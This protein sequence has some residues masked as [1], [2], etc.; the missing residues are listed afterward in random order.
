MPAGEHEFSGQMIPMWQ[1]TGERKQAKAS[2]IGFGGAAYGGKSYGML[3]MARVAAELWPGVQIAYFRRTYPELDGPGASIQKAY[4]VF[5]DVAKDTNGGKEWQWANGSTVFFRH[6][7]NEKDV[8]SYQSQQIDIL[9]LDEATHFTWFIVD[10]LLTRNRASGDV[11][12]TGFRP[13]AVM[14]SNPGNIGHQ[15]YSQVFDVEQKSGKH[16][17]LKLVQNPNGKNAQVYFI[18]AFLEDNQIGV[19]ADPEYES[20][21]TQRD[22][23]IA[24]ALRYGDWSLFAGQAF[25]GWTKDRIACEPFEIP[26]HWAR[27]RALDYGFVHPWAAGWFTVDP[28]TKRLYVYKAVKKSELTDTQQAVLMNSMTAADERITVTYASPD[29]WAR[30]TQGN[31]VFTSV[32]EYKAEGVLLTRADNERLNGKR[33]IDRLLFDALDGKPMVQVFEP[34][35]EVFACMRTLVRDDHNPEDV[36]KVD[37]DGCIAA[38]TL[39][40]TDKGDKPIEEV[41]ATDMVLTRKGYKMVTR[42]WL[43]QKNS[44]VYKA[45]FSDGRYVIGTGNHPVYVVGRGFINLDT[46]SHGDV[47]ITKE[48]ILCQPTQLSLMDTSLDG[49]QAL[50]TRRIR[51][52]IRRVA[53][54]GSAVLVSFIKKFGRACMEK[55]QKIITFTTR[56]T[57]HLITILQTLNV[58]IGMTIYPLIQNNMRLASSTWIEYASWQQSGTSRK[59]AGNG[60]QRSQSLHGKIACYKRLLVTFVK[61]NIKC[62]SK[63]RLTIALRFAGLRRGGEAARMMFRE[64][65]QFAEKILLQ[66]N[67][68]TH[69]HAHDCVVRVCDVQKLDNHQDV[70]NLTVMDEHE[71]F[72]NG[73][74]VHNC[75]DM[76]RYGLSNINQP[77]KT[78]TKTVHPARGVKAIW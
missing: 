3:I 33:K 21:L 49:T 32:D 47:I 68:M 10:Y 25:P 17:S 15:W 59:L 30:K 52:I 46:L 37:G 16:E 69:R 11:K 1:A 75:Y 36:K 42:A 27:W 66:I 64:L 9:L 67:M 12:T 13:F 62:S 29:M 77:T 22:P 78:Q 51:D 61:R 50:K 18:P 28:A 14:P 44:V 6:C 63:E 23:E 26:E 45:T 70:Y 20:R 58:S 76:L 56:I 55:F 43:K 48:N 7:Q 74:L 54:T 73:V 8:Y 38:G 72:A 71:F 19:A 4:G 34:Y 39:V 31:K 41:I 40:T 57:T 2:L 35:Y 53:I 5:G 24:R 65:V 60:I